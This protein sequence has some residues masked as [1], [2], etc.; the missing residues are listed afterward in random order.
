MKKYDT[1]TI[2]NLSLDYNIDYLDNLVVE[3]GGAALYSS[4]SAYAL[5]H[6]V[7]VVTKLNPADKARLND[8]FIPAEDVYYIPSEHST[9]IRNKYFTADKERRDCA[10]LSQADGFVIDDIPNVDCAIY[11]LAGLIYGDFDGRLMQQLSKRGA[12]AVDV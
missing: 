1:L 7:G 2:G 4:A 8:F 6:S 5:G 12:V 11:H 9:S 3:I 10:C